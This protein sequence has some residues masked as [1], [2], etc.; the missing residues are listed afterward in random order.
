MAHTPHPMVALCGPVSDSPCLCH[1]GARHH[2]G[3]I[4]F[5]VNRQLHGARVVGDFWHSVFV[6][7]ASPPSVRGTGIDPC[8]HRH[9][10]KPP[11]PECSEPPQ[12]APILG[13]RPALAALSNSDSAPGWP[14]ENTKRPLNTGGAKLAQKACAQAPVSSAAMAARAALP[15]AISCSALPDPTPMPPMTWPSSLIGKPPPNSM[16]CLPLIDSNL[17]ACPALA[18]FLSA[19]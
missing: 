8:R 18:P 5:H 1:P 15:T 10:A 6:R 14:I 7:G 12:S 4:P 11:N 13:K 9:R 2:N 19:H 16:W 17:E 3:R